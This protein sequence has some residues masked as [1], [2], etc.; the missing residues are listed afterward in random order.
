MA[1]PEINLHTNMTTN[2]SMKSN[3]KFIKFDHQQSNRAEIEHLS[4][5]FLFNREVAQPSN[6]DSIK[7]SGQPLALGPKQHIVK[8]KS[9][10]KSSYNAPANSAINDV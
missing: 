8:R 4:P 5:D 2:K 9:Y 7:I 3:I 6:N 10:L 1:K